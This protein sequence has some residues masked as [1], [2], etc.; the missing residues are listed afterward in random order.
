MTNIQS[1]VWFECRA[2]PAAA[3]VAPA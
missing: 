1:S 2:T 3:G